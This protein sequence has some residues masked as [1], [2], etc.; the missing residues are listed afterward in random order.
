MR[1][2]GERLSICVRA[3]KRDRGVDGSLMPDEELTLILKLR[4]EA[5]KGLKSWRTQVVAAGAAVAAVGFK[6]GA[7]WDKATKTIV[8]GTGATGQALKGLQQDYQAVAKFGENSATA[9]ADL[10]THLGLPGRGAAKRR[11][12]RAQSAG[13][14]QS[15]RRHGLAD[16]ARCA[17]Q[18]QWCFSINW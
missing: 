14:H 9:V 13:Q 3:T 12:R 5:T 7:D 15:V 11:R 2:V 4:D 10:N 18:T 8:A 17:G 16:G 1:V 6:A